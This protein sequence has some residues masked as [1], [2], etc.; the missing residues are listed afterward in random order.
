MNEGKNS[1]DCTQKELKS[2][3]RKPQMQKAG[4]RFRNYFLGTVKVQV[5]TSYSYFYRMK[6]TVSRNESGSF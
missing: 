6:G 2:P 5:Y 4:F 3:N 1:L